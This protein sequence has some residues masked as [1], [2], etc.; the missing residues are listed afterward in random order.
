MTDRGVLCGM[1]GHYRAVVEAGIFDKKGDG[2][3][4]DVCIPCRDIVLADRCC[5]CGTRVDES[6]DYVLFKEEGAAD[7]DRTEGTKICDEC[8]E[9]AL[10]SPDMEGLR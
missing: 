9:E 6:A 2:L 4:I 8:R 7:R 10:A 1:C 5:I 3:V